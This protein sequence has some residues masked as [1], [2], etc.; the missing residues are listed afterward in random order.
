MLILLPRLQ[1]TAALKRGINVSRIHA[2]RMLC[3]KLAEV[4]K[5][6]PNRQRRKN[7]MSVE[8]VLAA[9]AGGL[10]GAPLGAGG[11]AGGSS[12]KASGSGASTGNKKKNKGKK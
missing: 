5:A 6:K 1:L 9:Q 2:E 8:A 11:G 7:A 3:I 4:L 10:G 12:S